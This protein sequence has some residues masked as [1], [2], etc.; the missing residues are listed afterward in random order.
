MNRTIKFKAK[1]IDNNEW[2]EGNFIKDGKPDMREFYIQ[3]VPTFDETFGTLYEVD[4]NTIGQ[5][6]GLEDKNGK[7]IFEGDI[8]EFTFEDIGK[9]K[10]IVYFN[11]KYA[12]FL[13]NPIANFEFTKMSEGKVI[14]N[15]YDNPELLK[16]E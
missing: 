11:D 14:G 15:I 3:T 9:Q 4:P 13:L 8:L 5:F 10:A 16:G 6:T 7:E 12:A 2:V 1:R